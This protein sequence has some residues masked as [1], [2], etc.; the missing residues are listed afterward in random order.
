M[1]NP[2]GMEFI[3]RFL[4]Y[5]KSIFSLA[6]VVLWT[7]FCSVVVMATVLITGKRRAARFATSRLWAR[8]IL[9]VVGVTWELRG[10]E[11]LPAKGFLYLFNHTSHFDILTIFSASPRFC[12]FGAKYELFSIPVF[13]QAMKIA[14]ALPIVRNNRQKVMQ[15]YKEAEERVAEGDVFAL[16]PEGTRCPGFGKLGDFKSG[17]YFFAVNAQMPIV[18]IVLMGCEK[19]LPRKGILPNWGVW[20]QKVV[21]EILPPLYPQGRSEEQ[22]PFLKQKSR[23]MMQGCLN[24]YWIS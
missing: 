2:L 11:N 10:Q 19:V 9:S 17:P 8:T 12:Y 21:V 16:A 24:R 14:G 18:P 6:F 20:K 13:G 1:R 3:F 15:V 7:L 5:P 23:E 22:I 4:S